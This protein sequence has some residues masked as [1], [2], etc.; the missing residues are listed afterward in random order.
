MSALPAWSAPLT[1]VAA[2][3]NGEMISMRDVDRRA[4]PEL[5][6]QGLDPQNPAD[7]PRAAAIRHTALE[8]LITEKILMQ[9]AKRLK[10]DISD[11]MVE[12]ELERAIAESQLSRDE[13]MRQLSQQGLG[14]EMLRSNLVTQQLINRMVISKVVVTQDEINEYYRGHAGSLP[15]SGQM[16]LALIIYPATENAEQWA[17]AIAKGQSNFADVARKVSVGPNPQEGGDLGFMELDD[18]APNLREAAETLKPGQTSDLFNIE[19]NKAQVR[20]LESTSAQSAVAE[21]G[22]PSPAEAARIEDIL[23]RPRL[24]ARFK[25]YTEQVRAKALVDIRY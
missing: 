9:E 22:T 18:L 15:V 24:E 20:L 25:E 14:V 2:V 19:F 6:R 13:F 11:A 3:V 21:A 16:R 8:S 1:G 4:T 12:A 23:R 10:I 5:L 17:A 7:P